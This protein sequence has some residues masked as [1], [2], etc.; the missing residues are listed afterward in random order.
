MRLVAVTGWGREDDRSR[1]RD[2]GFDSHLTKP[3]NPSAVE[4]AL[5]AAE[6]LS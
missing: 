6:V 2:A 3:V 4:A 5:S 1:S